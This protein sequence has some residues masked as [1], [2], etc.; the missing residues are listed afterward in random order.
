M[1]QQ[2]QNSEL[3]AIVKVGGHQQK[4]CEGEHVLVPFM[5][6]AQRGQQVTWEHVL[7]IGGDALQVGNP[8]INGSCVQATVLQEEVKGAKIRVFKKKRRKG[9]HKTNGHRQKQTKL[10]VD[11]IAVEN[12]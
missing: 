8:Y 3:Y 2:Q 12:G 4:V 1:A 11:S 9:Y 10:R 6:Q 7:L 5:S